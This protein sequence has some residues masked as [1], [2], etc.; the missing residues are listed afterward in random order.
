[1][2]VHDSEVGKFLQVCSPVT[3]ISCCAAPCQFPVFEFGAVMNKMVSDSMH[4]VRIKSF[5]S[6]VTATLRFVD[7]AVVVVDCIEGCTH[8]DCSLSSTCSTS[9]C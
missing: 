1:M 8:G 3:T 6:V 7:G 2:G 5:S 4:Q 9:D